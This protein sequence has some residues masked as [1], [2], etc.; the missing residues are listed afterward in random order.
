MPLP[1]DARRLALYDAA[2]AKLQPEQRLAIESLRQAGNEC[3]TLEYADRAVDAIETLDLDDQ[4]SV[5]FVIG[6][7]NYKTATHPRVE[8]WCNNNAARICGLTQGP[9]KWNFGGHGYA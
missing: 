5:M 3:P 2:M 4:L 6:L 1:I 7:S 9:N 8:K